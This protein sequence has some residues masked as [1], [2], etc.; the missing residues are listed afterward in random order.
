MEAEK[1]SI[2]LDLPVADHHVGAAGEDRRDQLRDV[3]GPVLVVGVGVDDHVGAELQRGV[4]P[5]L[6]GGREALVVGQPDDVVDAVVSRDLDRAIGGA[7]VDHE[8]LDLVEPVDLAGQL[9]QHARE[10]R[11]LVRQGIWITSFIAGPW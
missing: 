4:E 1:C 8:P 3:G 2:V 9:A 5:G 11:L 7:I 6:E 10:R